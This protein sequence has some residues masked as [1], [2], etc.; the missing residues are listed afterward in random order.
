MILI[1]NIRFLAYTLSS[2]VNELEISISLKMPPVNIVT[3]TV[4]S[5][6]VASMISSILTTITIFCVLFI[7]YLK[8]KQKGNKY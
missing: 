7:V 5:V 2:D 3:V 4:V 1:R 6:I 8:H